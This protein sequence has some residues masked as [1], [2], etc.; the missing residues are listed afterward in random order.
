MKLIKA[1][2]RMKT[3]D[4]LKQWKLECDKRFKLTTTENRLPYVI[5]EDHMKQVNKDHYEQ[6]DMIAS[7]KQK[8]AKK[9]H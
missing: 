1:D 6:K 7:K 4:E 2:E 9:L 5:N 8:T 3:I